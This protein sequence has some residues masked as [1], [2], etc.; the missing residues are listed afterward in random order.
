MILFLF[1]YVG[2]IELVRPAIA[3]ALTRIPDLLPFGTS[4]HP[5][6]ERDVIAALNLRP[7]TPGP[8]KIG[9]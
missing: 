5:W 7:V 6:W 8:Q 3:G 2:V 9:L 1:F 4:I